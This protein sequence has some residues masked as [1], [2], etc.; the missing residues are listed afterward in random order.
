MIKFLDK[1]N[2]IISFDLIDNSICYV[3]TEDQICID[4]EILFKGDSLYADMVFCLDKIIAWTDMRGRSALYDMNKKNL[5]FCHFDI[6]KETYS[7]V[8]IDLTEQKKI[9][10][11]HRKDGVKQFCLFDL[12]TDT[13]TP[14]NFNISHSFQGGKYLFY[15]ENDVFNTGLDRKLIRISISGEVLWEYNPKGEF[16]NYTGEK[17]NI[18]IY[19]ILGIFNNIL[20]VVLTSGQLVGLNADTGKVEAHDDDM[21][22]QNHGV[23]LIPPFTQLDDRCGVIMGLMD[24]G[25]ARLNLNS[26]NKLIKEYFDLS[27]TMHQHQIEAGMQYNYPV[28]KQHIY[29]SGNMN[30]KIGIL[31]RAKLEVV[32]SYELDMKKE[33]ISQ[34]REMKVA[35]NRWYVQDRHNTLHVFERE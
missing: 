4:R 7:V 8:N 23:K 1:Q 19:R 30:G 12:T 34:I 5:M 26:Q 10:F 31:D 28:D 18:E 20:W 14:I 13:I 24:T 9:F 2:D 11:S 17:E 25:F 33:G 29:F 21:G 27:A 32:W 22:S 16:C 15:K 35:G 3:N 6:S